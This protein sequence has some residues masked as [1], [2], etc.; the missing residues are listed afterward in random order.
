MAAERVL[1]L[2]ELNRDVTRGVRP[3]SASQKLALSQRLL[4]GITAREVS[5]AF[6]ATFDPSRALF[7]AELPAS[8][9]VP[10]EAGHPIDASR[11]GRRCVAREPQP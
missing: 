8:D 2:R 10:G 1:S 5:D 3:M 6:A 7:I 11:L 9:D 4:P